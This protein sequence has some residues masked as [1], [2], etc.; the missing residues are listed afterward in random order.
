MF[1]SGR[2]AEGRR[3][4]RRR[5]ISIC[6]GFTLHL[7]LG[8]WA[9][10]G[11]STYIT[12]GKKGLGGGGRLPLTLTRAPTRIGCCCCN[13][14][15]TR[16]HR[17]IH[18]TDN[19][20]NIKGKKRSRVIDINRYRPI[21]SRN[22]WVIVFPIFTLTAGIWIFNRAEHPAASA[23]NITRAGSPATILLK[24]TITTSLDTS[25]TTRAII[26]L[27]HNFRTLG[28]TER[29]HQ[30]TKFNNNII[31]YLIQWGKG[32]R[33]EHQAGKTHRDEE[34]IIE[35]RTGITTKK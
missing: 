5:S 14:S 33:N 17:Q 4:L 15:D 34:N 35:T 28:K 31:N 26:R 21:I 30:S 18:Y 9:Q 22:Y 11:A 3:C 6:K 1:C 23:R 19:N 24:T 10:R 29:N 13:F 7:Q 27:L 8:N 12:N 32:T 2:V 25:C 16:H 20:K